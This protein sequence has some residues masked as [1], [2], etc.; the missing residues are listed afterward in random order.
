MP[1]GGRGNVGLVEGWAPAL[2]LAPVAGLLDALLDLAHRVQVLVQLVLIVGAD[3][4]PQAMGFVQHR[5]QHTPVSALDAVLEQPVESQGGVD[6]QGGGSRGRAP[7][8]VR[9]VEHGVVLVD[10]RIGP[11]A[12]DHQAGHLGGAPIA[13]GHH[14]VEAGPGTN[15]AAVGQRRPGKQV[16]GLGAVD[17]ALERL[18]IVEPADEEHSLAKI[19]Q[20][21]QHPAELHL[22]PLSLGPP[23]L[24]VKPV[25]CKQHSQADRGL[26][27]RAQ[28][29]SGQSIPNRQ[30][31]HPGQRHGDAQ[32]PQEFASRK[33]S[34]V[35]DRPRWIKREGLPGY[36][37]SKWSPN[38]P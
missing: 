36:F 5:V 11:F 27:G 3:V 1:S 15:L 29:R 10:P 31:L 7:G 2:H 19:G 30:R 25:A 22:F 26:T 32:P 4:P 17:I 16:A 13:L 21:F 12:T 38:A 34:V 9:A 37:T 8:D 14:L 28:A 24:A 18:G 20:G 35:H 6:F 33:R 23:L